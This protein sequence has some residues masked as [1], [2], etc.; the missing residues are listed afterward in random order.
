M[1]QIYATAKIHPNVILGE[2]NRIGKN[3]VIEI[4]GNNP[5]VKAEIG[6]NNIIN[7]NTRIFI[8]GE[9]KF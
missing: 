8:H 7:E 3:V 4:V 5:N 2:Y 6:D 1:N 9:F